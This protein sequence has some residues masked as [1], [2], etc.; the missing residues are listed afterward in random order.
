M[1]FRIGSVPYINAAPLTRWL[2]TDAGRRYAEVVYAPPS[3]LAQMLEQRTIDVALV[4]SVEHFRRPETRFVDG[5]AIASRREVLSVRLFSKTTIA[6]IQTVAL[7]T[8]SLTSAALTRIVLERAYGVYPNYRSAP[9]D[10]NVMLQSADAALLIGDLGMTAQ[11][12][13]VVQYLDLGAAWHAWTGLPFVWA[14]WLMN[15]ESPAEPIAA[16]LHDAYQWGKVHLPTIVEAESQRTGIPLEL[17]RRYLSEV[18]VYE[19]D[20]ACLQGLERFRNEY[21]AMFS[22]R[23]PE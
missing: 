4:S 12:T 18:M 22:E 3:R 10:L 5:L 8:S 2:E 23:R 11:H 7:D 13:A 19:T 16:L 20:A 21:Q 17:C 9:P 14:V 15:P 1:R 6:R